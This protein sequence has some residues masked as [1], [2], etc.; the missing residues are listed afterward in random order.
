MGT[1]AFMAW[2]N[3][4]GAVIPAPARTLGETSPA[5]LEQAREEAPDALIEAVRPLSARLEE[6]ARDHP[7]LVMLLRSMLG[8]NRGA[9]TRR[10]R[11]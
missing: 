8:R 4:S 11:R 1:L 3:R 5:E 7:E 2:L 6:Q 9:P 10:R